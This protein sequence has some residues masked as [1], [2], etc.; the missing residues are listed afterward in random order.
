MPTNLGTIVRV[1]LRDEWGHEAR[2]FTPWLAEPDNLN[3]LAVA[4]ELSELSLIATEH[5]VGD[6]RLDLLCTDGQDIVIIENQLQKTDHS[7]LGQIIAYSAGV[8]AKKIIWVAESF[9]PEHTAALHFLNRNTTD[10]LSFFAVALELWR[11]DSSRSAPKFEVIAKPDNWTKTGTEQV[12]ATTTISPVQQLQLKFWNALIPILA[13][14]APHIRPQRPLPRHHL[15]HAIGRAGFGLN[16]TAKCRDEI[17][18]VELYISGIN[19]NQ[20]FANLSHQAS[21]IHEALGFKLDWQELPNTE[22]CRVASWLQ[23]APLD[24][25]ARWPEYLNWL[26]ERLLAMEQ[27]FRPIVGALP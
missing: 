13:D 10:E 5:W 8:N 1:P 15:N 25:E 27:V 9:R 18:G 16:A 21:E 23:N 14:R 19:A 6:F 22:A 24:D 3:R 2:D 20:H 17:I 4:L 12:R 7:H 11:I 26:T